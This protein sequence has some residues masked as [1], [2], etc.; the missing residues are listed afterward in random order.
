[1][2]KRSWTISEF[3]LKIIGYITMTL[4]HIGLF[5]VEVE[6]LSKL[7]I[8]FR[9]IGRIA[10][11]LFVFMIIEGVRHTKN[12][13]KYLFRLCSIDFI[14]IAFE[15]LVLLILGIDMDMA[16]PFTDL[17]LIALITKLLDNKNKTSFFAIIPI[18]Y[19]VLCT[20][21]NVYEMSTYNYVK[22]LPTMIR[23][24]EDILGLVLAIGFYY[25]SDIIKI[26]MRANENTKNLDVASYDQ[27]MKNFMSAAIIIIVGICA[28][29]FYKFIVVS[30]FNQLLIFDC[31]A[32]LPILF[33][34]GE[35]GYNKKWFQTFSYLY[36][37][38]HLV[39]IYVV[40][41]LTGVIV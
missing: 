25:T 12:F 17:I 1:M 24:D 6:S 20:V 41:F 5:F 32:A 7:G 9:S 18:A 38:L 35:R 4:D 26:A 15:L 10:F 31:F 14:I 40:L 3:V 30:E 23:T 19:I 27:K 28:Y 11:P 2:K 22:F 13:K 34:S 29:V 8:I 36:F 16:C 37:P 21:V 33:Y 39:I